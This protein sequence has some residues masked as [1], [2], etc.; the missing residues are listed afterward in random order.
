VESGQAAVQGEAVKLRIT[1]AL[2]ERAQENLFPNGKLTSKSGMTRTELRALHRRG[3]VKKSFVKVH[4]GAIQ[5]A[6]LECFWELT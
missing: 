5:G 3:V 2:Y 4:E 1:D 6:T